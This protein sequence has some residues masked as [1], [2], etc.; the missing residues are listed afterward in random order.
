MAR[1]N[2]RE[3][4]YRDDDNRRFLLK[5]LAEGWTMTSWRVHAWVFM[6]NHCHSRIETPEPNP[7][8]GMKS[9]FRRFALR[10]ISEP[11]QL[12]RLFRAVRVALETVR[13]NEKGRRP[14]PDENAEAL[15]LGLV[16]GLL[17]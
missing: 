5:T 2:R 12:L 1:G 9:N 7:A 4:I 13:E 16:S 10:N 17:L 6:G 15:G 8:A 11:A 14:E 3:S